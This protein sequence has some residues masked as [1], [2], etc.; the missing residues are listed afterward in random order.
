MRKR[1]AQLFCLLSVSAGI[2]CLFGGCLSGFSKPYVAVKYY[3]LATPPQITL[4]QTQVKILPLESTE[5]AKYKMI[6]QGK[7]NEVILDDYNKWIQPP[8]LLITRYLQS[9]F[10]QSGTSSENP[11]LFISGNVFMFKIDLQT[12]TASLGVNYVI[13]GEP[14]DV[15]KPI[16]RNS[17][18]FYCKF[19]K[20]GPN[21]FVRAMSECA[22]QLLAV[23][24]KDIKSIKPDKVKAKNQK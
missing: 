18:V 24:A 9:A 5:P 23:I 4:T 8:S 21:Y 1:L 10:K 17:T 12:N 6:Y 20:Q 13:K 2:I 7:D 15:I 11:V 16:S 14:D 22:G 19:K 3:D